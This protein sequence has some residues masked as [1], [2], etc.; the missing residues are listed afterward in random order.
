MELM[1]E[2]AFQQGIAAHKEGKLEDAERFYRSVLQSQP[3]HPDANHNLGVIAV[4]ANK[5]DTALQLFQTALEANPNVEQYWH[6]YVDTL[7][8][9][10]QFE[11]AEKAVERAIGKGFNAKKLEARLN[12]SEVHTATQGPSQAQIGAVLEHYQ[13]G[14]YLEAEKLASLLTQEFPRH[15]FGY[16]A[17]GI[18]LRRLGRVHESIVASQKSVELAP[19]DTEAHSN[20]GNTLRES[21]RLEEAEVSYN[22]AI[23][24]KPDSAEAHSNLGITLQELGR[25][26]EATESF[27]QA[28]ELQPDLTEAHSNLG[29]TLFGQGDIGGALNCFQRSCDSNRRGNELNGHQKI[30]PGICKFKLVHDIEQFEYLASRFIDKDRFSRLAS[31]YSKIRDETTWSSETGLTK[32]DPA[33]N[34]ALANS[35]KLLHQG[36]AG[37]VEQAVNGSLDTNSIYDKYFSHEFGLT[38]IDDFLGTE[39]LESL[40]KF[41]LESTIWFEQKVGGYLGAYL[42]D[43]LASPLIL[44]IAS[45]LKSRFP[46]IIKN[47]SLNQVWAY[48]YDSRAS[49]PDSDVSGIRIHADFA[50]INVNFWVTQSEANLDPDS[51]GMVV[52]NTEA[53]KDWSF[54]TYNNNLSRIQEEL[55]K[56]DGGRVV[57]PHR[58]NRM[59]IFNSNLFHET[60]KYYFK[61][62]YENRRINVTMLFGR[63]ED[64]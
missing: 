36:E 50:A 2:Q 31:G 6:S 45:E 27:R 59:V 22:Q 56:S 54:D 61:E 8:K 43:G 38:Y 39:A 28:I 35:S 52:Y 19:E 47:H 1:V 3:A 41:L 40:R 49:C 26:D 14:S 5:A 23:A 57:I 25:L 34:A 42:N 51:G 30:L 20:L 55:S 44:Q 11:A 63:R 58:G 32:V 37:R 62:G 16:K 48:K 24:L 7:V 17:L 53:P 64:N 29:I 4:S 18:V 15:P 33:F 10:G 46:L 9:T 13:N 60:D 12:Q 21:G